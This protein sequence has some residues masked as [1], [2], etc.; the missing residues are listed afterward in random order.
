MFI[1]R[2]GL[3]NS[4]IEIKAVKRFKGNKRYTQVKKIAHKHTALFMILFQ[5]PRGFRKCKS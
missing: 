5:I 4:D 3:S 1:I 2:V